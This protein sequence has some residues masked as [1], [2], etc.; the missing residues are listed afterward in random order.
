MKVLQTLRS[1][2]F[3]LGSR[4]LL[5]SLLLASLAGAQD[6][7]I[8]TDDLREPSLE[9]S[10]FCIIENATV[11]TATRPAFEG[12]VY[13]LNG[14]IAGVGAWDGMIPADVTRIDGT[15]MHLVPGIVDNHSHMAIE[16]GINEGTVSITAEVRIA[17][18]VD[19]DDVGIYRAL[20]GGVTAIRQLHGSANTIGG[21]D[22]VI[23]L[24]WGKDRKASDL[25]IEDAPQ[26]IKFALGENVK[27]SNWGRPGR[28]PATRMGVETLIDRAFVR[29]KEYQE[30]WRAYERAVQAG[31]N[32]VP[33]RK[34]LRLDTLAG[35]L[36]GTVHVHSHCYRADEIV[37]LIRASQRHGFQIATLQHVLEGYKVAHEMA[38]A[39]V[40]GSTFSDWWAY[41]VEAYDGIPQNAAFMHRAGVLSSINSDS[42]EMIR[43]LFDEAAKSM[44]YADL[45]PVTALQLV[46]L[47]S[48]KQLGLGHRM[49]SIEVGKDAD[50]VLLNGDPMSSFSRVEWTMVDGVI[51]YTRWDPFELVNQPAP[52]ASIDVEQRPFQLGEGKITALVGGTLHTMLGDPVKNCAL[53]IQGD[54]MWLARAVTLEDNLLEPTD[55]RPADPNGSE[56]KDIVKVDEIIDVTGQH[57]WPGMIAMRSSLG[58][59]EVGAVRATVDSNEIGENQPDVRVASSIHADSAHIPVTRWT[60][61]TRAQ[62]CPGGSGPVLGQSAVIDLD[63][64]TWEELLTHDRDML[65]LRFPTS[66]NRAPDS[67]DGRKRAKER[68]K[69]RKERVQVL[70]DLLED[71]RHYG[72]RLEASK[73]AQVPAPPYDPRLEAMVPYAQGKRTIALYANNAQTILHALQFAQEQ[74]LDVVLYGAKEAWKVV[75]AVKQS[76]VSVVLGPIWTLPSS[77]YDPFDSAFAGPAVLARAGIPFAIACADPENERNL[78]FH[79]AT[80]VA[81]G[82][83]PEEGARAVTLYPAR[84]LGLDEEL[85]SLRNGNRADILVT[86]GH[87]LEIT[88]NVQHM[89]I[90]GVRIDHTDNRQTRLYQRFLKRLERLQPK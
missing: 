16:R 20:A 12:T 35:I 72:R 81:Y 37:M 15:G 51:E 5:P 67:E 65:H 3:S 56:V 80:A 90:D 59:Y 73:D 27:R 7:P 88:S 78:P 11:H 53:L 61:I 63:G 39:N 55:P 74:E 43:R 24:R 22:E 69:Q 32:P 19:P 57:V 13:V 66:S 41:K 8:E 68:E 25:V 46:T 64:E 45:D 89:F 75:D 34:D 60:G 33:P 62:V 42:D 38:Q 36:E 70:A 71:A 31:E 77:E 10:A 4:M 87:L 29:A 83:P 82:L 76:G 85:G 52:V 6:H 86:D 23:K 14:K 58:L 40:A 21:Q 48:A 2:P 26:G 30:E 50:L 18:E 44:R 49:G 9:V 84:I 54:R 47:N 17:D 1:Q 79:A 28:F